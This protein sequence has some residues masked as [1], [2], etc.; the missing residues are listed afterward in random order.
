MIEHLQ[1]AGLSMVLAVSRSSP[2]PALDMVIQI[3]S[4]LLDVV[5]GLVAGAALL[6][7][8]MQ[9]QRIPMSARSGNPFGNFIFALTDWIVLPLRR[10]LPAWG[11]WDTAS[12]LAVYL[13]ELAQLAILLLLG[14]QAITS[15]SLLPV[16]ALFGVARLVLS[17]ATGLVIVY[18]VMSW[19]QTRS[20]MTD[21]L[22]KLCAPALRPLRKILPLLGGIDLSLLALLLLVQIGA[23][24]LGGLQGAVLR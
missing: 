13:L 23:I 7:L 8:Y 24:L 2:L 11:R 1:L 19:V 10:I 9:Y 18:A 16:L 12:L 5:V 4:L 3:V 14:G 20:P 17:L 6:R 22:E 15:L 21:L